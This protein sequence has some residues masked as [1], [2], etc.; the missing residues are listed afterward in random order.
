MS[1]TPTQARPAS[2]PQTQAERSRAMRK[3]LREATLD[4]LIKD[5]YAKTTVSA[6]CERAGVSRGAYVH[7]YASKHELI[8]DVANALLR[9]SHRRL[10]KA[11]LEIT[12]ESDRLQNLLIALWQEIF[13][14]PLYSAYMALLMASQNDAEL[15]QTLRSISA[16]QLMLLDVAADH[17]FEPAAGKS[18]KSKDL[19]VLATWTLSG[20]ASEAHLANNPGYLRRQL[21]ILGQIMSAQ[22]RPRKGVTTPPSKI[23]Y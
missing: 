6:V 14:T 9:Q 3:R 18:V 4:C 1:T 20:M 16:Q 2:A 13:S 22:L 17:Y 10:T 11:V 15:A 23:S 5:G 19:F 8:L 12:D 21:A 7:Q